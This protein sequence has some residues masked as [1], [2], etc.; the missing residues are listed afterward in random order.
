MSFFSGG[1]FVSGLNLTADRGYIATNP[2]QSLRTLT[3]ANWESLR[4]WVEEQIPGWEPQ[5]L[6]IIA[7]DFVGPLPLCSLVIALNQK[8]ARKKSQT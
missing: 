8:L 4:K 2:T 1:F 5:S 3:F 6:N 7:G